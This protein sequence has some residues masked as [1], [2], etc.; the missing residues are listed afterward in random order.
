MSIP[1]RG[2]KKVPGGAADK[3]KGKKVV[4]EV[5]TGGDAESSHV[6]NIYAGVED[7][8]IQADEMYPKWLWSLAD[9]PKTYGELSSMFVYGKGIE[10][11]KEHDYRRFLRLH[12]KLVIKVNNARLRKSKSGTE[13]KI[14]VN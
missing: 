10:D 11:A 2:P 13:A 6:F 12:R 3:K 4:S 9:P 14:R 1:M 7:P 8:T 5:E